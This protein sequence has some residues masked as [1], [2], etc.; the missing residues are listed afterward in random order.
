MTTRDKAI[1]RVLIAAQKR[2]GLGTARAPSWIRDRVGT[3]LDV[4]IVRAACDWDLV[5]GR[6][7]EDVPA[8]NDLMTSLRVGETRFLRDPQQWDAVVEH[9]CNNVRPTMPIFALSA[10]C[11]TG[12]EAYT[13]AM[14]LSEKGRRY[15]VLGVDRSAEAIETA[16]AGRY[17]TD[18]VRELPRAF[19]RR[20]FSMEA[21]GVSVTHPLRTNVSFEVRD[22]MQWIPRGPFHLVLFK[23]VLLY[24]AERSGTRVAVRLANS[25][26]RGGIL[27]SAASEAVR[28]SSVLE[29]IRLAPGVVAFHNRPP[30]EPSN[31]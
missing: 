31:S 27:V 19:V 13:L 24:F 1:D 14:L 12:E 10:G 26:D 9:L 18:Q 21:G 7:T 23:N 28:L 4:Y 29:P 8:M 2:F 5:A 22:L 15:H 6:L 16:R 3:F 17:S 20:Y 30:N 11:S 25:L